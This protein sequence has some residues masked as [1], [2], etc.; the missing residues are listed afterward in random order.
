MKGIISKHWGME[1]S[2]NAVFMTYSKKFEFE[3]PLFFLINPIL[4]IS[5]YMTFN[6]VISMVAWCMLGQKNNKL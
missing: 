1:I 3:Y 2:T 4:L 5:N 6:A